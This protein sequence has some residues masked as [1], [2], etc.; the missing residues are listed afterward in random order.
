MKINK[1]GTL[2]HY[3]ENMKWDELYFSDLQKYEH[4]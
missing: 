4:S 3:D 1:Q 2:Q